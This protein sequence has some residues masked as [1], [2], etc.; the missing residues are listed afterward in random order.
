MRGWSF[1]ASKL[2]EAQYACLAALKR[3]DD[4]HHGFVEL[5]MESITQDLCLIML[6]AIETW[7]PHDERSNRKVVEIFQKMAT[8]GKLQEE[9]VMNRWIEVLKGVENTELV[10]SCIRNI[11]SSPRLV[12]IWL[13]QSVKRLD[14]GKSFRPCV[15]PIYVLKPLELIEEKVIASTCTPKMLADL[16]FI[17]SRLGNLA[18]VRSYRAALKQRFGKELVNSDMYFH[19][20]LHFAASDPLISVADRLQQIQNAKTCF[21]DAEAD[22]I[23]VRFFHTQTHINSFRNGFSLPLRG[24]GNPR[25]Q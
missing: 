18:K 9:S 5:E 20:L 16:I 6:S 8:A 25:E 3:Y 24:G 7:K 1:D 13:E 17:H 2:I 21:A 11:F 19:L 23:G 15:S 22:G 10:H 4:A 14:D 12:E